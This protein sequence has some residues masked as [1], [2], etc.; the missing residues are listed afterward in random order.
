[1]LRARLE[2]AC[3]VLE[4]W[5]ESAHFDGKVVISEKELDDLLTALAAG[6]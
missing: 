6:E 5:L 2:Q 1:M 3:D 4:T